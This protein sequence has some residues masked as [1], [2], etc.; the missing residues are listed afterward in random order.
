[1]SRL[2]LYSKYKGKIFFHFVVL[3]I[4]EHLPSTLMI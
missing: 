2:M 1:M 4:E 3:N